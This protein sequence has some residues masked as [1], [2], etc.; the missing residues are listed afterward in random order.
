MWQ[1]LQ[2]VFSNPVQHFN[3]LGLHTKRV[4]ASKERSIRTYKELAK[5]IPSKKGK[6]QT[7]ARRKKRTSKRFSPSTDRSDIKALRNPLVLNQISEEIHHITIPSS[8]LIISNKR[9][10]RSI[11]IGA[12]VQLP[13]SAVDRGSSDC[14]TGWG[15]GTGAAEGGEPDHDFVAVGAGGAGGE[16]HVVAYVGDYVGSCVSDLCLLANIKERDS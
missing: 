4:A 16:P 10:N 6:N 3:D 14:G 11:S 8:L 7:P 13:S 15:N 9:V 5:H 2:L 12:A 1:E